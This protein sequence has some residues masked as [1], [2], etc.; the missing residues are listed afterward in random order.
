MFDEVIYN[1]WKVVR[2][3]SNDV[4]FSPFYDPDDDFFIDLTVKFLD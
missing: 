2:F 4:E 3:R 1:K